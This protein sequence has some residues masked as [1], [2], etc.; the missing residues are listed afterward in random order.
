MPSAYERFSTWGSF[1][2]PS[3]YLFFKQAKDK[4][5][6]L[7]FTPSCYIYASSFK[8]FYKYDELQLLIEPSEASSLLY[9]ELFFFSLCSYYKLAIALYEPL[10]T[11]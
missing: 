8:L 11:Y 3:L 9:Y 5:F 1:C 4:L 10:A 2:G 7:I 6:P